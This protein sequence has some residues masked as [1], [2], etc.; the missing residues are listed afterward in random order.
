[1]FAT[2]LNEREAFRAIFSF[3]QTLDMLDPKDVPNL[4]KAIINAEQFT[5][6]VIEQLRA[7]RQS[8]AKAEDVTP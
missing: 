2:Q 3:R 7:H 6:E 5:V 4:D 8:T 1:M